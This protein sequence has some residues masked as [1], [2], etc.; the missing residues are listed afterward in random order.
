MQN[1]AYIFVFSEHMCM[2]K[3]T[4]ISFI[5]FNSISALDSG[6]H[7]WFGVNCAV[8]VKMRSHQQFCQ[9]QPKPQPANTQLGGAL[10]SQLWRTTIHPATPY[11]LRH[12]TPGI[13]ALP[14]SSL[15]ITTV[16]TCSLLVNNLLVH[17][18]FISYSQL[19]QTL[20][21]TCS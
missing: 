4:Y 11:N 18:L 2:L 19:V 9:A 1:A 5:T 6:Y 17:Y 14:V 3:A 20:F 12:H 21:V 8:S 7:F 10:L 13:V 16:G 15:I